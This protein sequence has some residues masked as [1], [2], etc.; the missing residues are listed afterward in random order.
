[1]FFKKIKQDQMSKAFLLFLDS[2]C[3]YDVTQVTVQMN[4]TWPAGL[5]DEVVANLGSAASIDRDNNTLVVKPAAARLARML[6]QA[7]HRTEE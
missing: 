3:R 1:M 2:V 5:A 6:A 7:M 4:D